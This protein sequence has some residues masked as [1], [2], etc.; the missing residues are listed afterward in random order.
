MVKSDE[1]RNI[2]QK[3]TLFE[4]RHAAIRYSD[5]NFKSLRPGKKPIEA[6]IDEP[7]G[8]GVSER[9]SHKPD[10]GQDTCFPGQ[11]R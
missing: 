2:F 7:K 5:R 9:L 11:E 10:F 3:L 1:D 4:N 8:L 6:P